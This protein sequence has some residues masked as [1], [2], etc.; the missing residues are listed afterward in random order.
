[1][2]DRLLSLG[3]L[4]LALLGVV[5][6][7]LVTA[8]AFW[9]VQAQI[10]ALLRADQAQAA[11]LELR[12]F[13]EVD[14]QEGRDGLVRAM[15]RRLEAEPD[16]APLY[17]LADQDGRRITG[18]IEWPKDFP[19]DQT[20]RDVRENGQIIGA[21]AAMVLPDGARLLVGDDLSDIAN[22][23]RA[24][25]AAFALAMGIVAATA[26]AMGVVLNRLLLQRIGVFV[27]TSQRIMA[28]DLNERTPVAGNGGPFDELAQALN[29]MLDRNAA[30]IGQ[31]RAVTDAIA[32]DLRMPLQHIRANLERALAAPG[33]RER[34]DA[35]SR[36][37]TEGDT[38]LSTF[39]TLL[40]MARAEAGVGRDAFAAVDLADVC[41]D[42]VEMFGPIAEDKRQTLQLDAASV[43]VMG[44]AA[45]LRQAL[46]N[47][48]QNAIKYTPED[49][50]IRVTCSTDDGAANLSV[51]DNGPGIPEAERNQAVQPFGRLGRDRAID[52]AGLG[53]AL[54]AAIVKL[55]RGALTFSDARPGLRVDIRLPK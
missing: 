13:A 26:I 51:V 44:Q 5:F 9:L 29:A 1:M 35:I 14:R 20:W 48:V 53:L 19:T 46:A 49:G 15:L 28:G 31:L 25:V 52:G 41:E 34:L 3:P 40:E 43:V 42:I 16:L 11:K 33:E 45:F 54:V 30:L 22:L 32:H 37:M 21:A 55:H 10:E 24:L 47:L 38:A 18:T 36:A 17:V 6:V 39:N 12:L 7:A 8:A 27:A 4:R 50:V 2:S 23:R